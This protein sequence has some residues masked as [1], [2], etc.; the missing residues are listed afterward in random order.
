MYNV[1]N[2]AAVISAGHTNRIATQRPAETEP[3]NSACQMVWLAK[4][5]CAPPSPVKE[6]DEDMSLDFHRVKMT[7]THALIGKYPAQGQPPGEKDEA[8]KYRPRA[9]SS[10]QAWCGLRGI[11]P[12]A[13]L[14]WINEWWAAP[15]HLIRS[16]DAACRVRLSR[17]GSSGRHRL[18]VR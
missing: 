11:A 17:L 4:K 8:R 3:A 10:Y 2:A 15:D 6:P 16:L 9:G 14:I 1:R 12:D 18:G 7:N 5:R 13:A